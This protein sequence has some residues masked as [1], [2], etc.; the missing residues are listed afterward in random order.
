MTLGNIIL[1][2][3]VLQNIA[4]KTNEYSLDMD[5]KVKIL[6]MRI[7]FGKFVT[8]LQEDVKKFS[9]QI[10]P[11]NVKALVHKQYK[12][13]EDELKIESIKQQYSQEQQCYIR[14][15]EC[16]EVTVKQFNI[17]EEEFNQIVKV[18]IDNSIEI[19]GTKLSGPDFL[20]IVYNLFVS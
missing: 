7:Y 9:E 5:T 16:E 17:T 20:E 3:K 2:Y 4:F 18:N 13:K 19:N 15:R 14:Q 10:L 8:E 1:R 6:N 12:S 11:D